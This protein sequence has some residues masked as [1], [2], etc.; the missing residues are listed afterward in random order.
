MFYR[1][2]QLSCHIFLY[3]RI[4]QSLALDHRLQWSTAFEA[5]RNKVLVKGIVS[6]KTICNE[7]AYD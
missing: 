1:Q 5:T 2:A 3:T 4:T 6:A 7:R